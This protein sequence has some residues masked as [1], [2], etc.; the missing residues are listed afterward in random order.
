MQML[1]HLT[2]RP[3]Q[4]DINKQKNIQIFGASNSQYLGAF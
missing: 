3:S 4:T 1:Y 2:N